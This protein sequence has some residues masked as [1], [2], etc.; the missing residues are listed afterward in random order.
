MKSM[1]KFKKLSVLLMLIL[2]VTVGSCKKKKCEPSAVT[3]SFTWEFGGGNF[4]KSP[5]D[6]SEGIIGPTIEFTNTSTNAKS[7]V[8]DFGDGNTST[9]ANPTHTYSNYEVRTVTLKATNGS[10]SATATTVI[11]VPI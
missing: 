8:W 9:A 7:Y 6:R 3:A 1:K 5:T 2:A 4:K 11:D 10:S